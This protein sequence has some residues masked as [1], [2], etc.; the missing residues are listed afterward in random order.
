MLVQFAARYRA[1]LRR[2]LRHD[3]CLTSHQGRVG[4]GLAQATCSLCHRELLSASRITNYSPFRGI[5]HD[6]D[7]GQFVIPQSGM[8]YEVVPYLCWRSSS[9]FWG[10]VCPGWNI[11]CSKPLTKSSLNS[12]TLVG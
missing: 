4:I 5:T 7:A 6:Y 2:G 10:V 9:I 12:F 3:P 1:G 11:N 8:A